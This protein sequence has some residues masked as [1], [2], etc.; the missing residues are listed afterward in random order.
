VLPLV[1]VGEDAFLLRAYQADLKF[2]RD[3]SDKVV[4]VDFS[5]E[6]V[7]VS[8]ERFAEE[9]AGDGESP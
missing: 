9:P 6:G 2:K 7:P 3:K 8:L 5:F 4:G 1:P